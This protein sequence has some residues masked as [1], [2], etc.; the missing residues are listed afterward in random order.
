[1]SLN[2]VRREGVVK[3]SMRI[4][5]LDG[6]PLTLQSKYLQTVLPMDKDIL[7][8]SYGIGIQSETLTG[9]K[10]V[11]VYTVTEKEIL[12][13]E[14]FNLIDGA[15]TFCRVGVFTKAGNAIRN[16]TKM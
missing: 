4:L 6:A 5:E 11:T 12:L 13:W 3:R 8:E 7:F 15:G 1:M 9:I 14:G 16:K 10:V 2:A